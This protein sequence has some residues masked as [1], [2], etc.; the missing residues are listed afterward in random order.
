MLHLEVIKWREE[1]LG[2]K[3][4]KTVHSKHNYAHVLYNMERFEEAYVV[5][6]GVIK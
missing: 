3:H 2:P 5:Y 1:L 4:E 6:F